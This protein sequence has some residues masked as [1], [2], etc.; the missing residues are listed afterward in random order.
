MQDATRGRI[1]LVQTHSTHPAVRA[2]FDS[3][4]VRGQEPSHLHRALAHAPSVLTPLLHLTQALSVAPA[5]TAADRELAILRTAQLCDSDYL[6]AK[7]EQTALQAGVDAEQQRELAGWIESDRFSDRQRV[8]L[9]YVDAMLGPDGVRDGVYAPLA[10]HLSE[11]AI[12][13]LTVTT[14]LYSG[15]ARVAGAL[16]LPPEPGPTPGIDA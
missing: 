11:D 6:F 2:A 8:I 15:L 4:R 7:H 13:E 12:V 5:T 1:S 16:S 14:A 10:L 3:I 9:N